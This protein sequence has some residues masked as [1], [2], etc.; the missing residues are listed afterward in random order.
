MESTKSQKL[1]NKIGILILSIV[2]LTANAVSPILNTMMKAFP[3]VSPTTVQS[4]MT[5]PTF[6]IMIFTLLAGLMANIVGKKRLLLIGLGFYT[7]GGMLPLIL[8]D[9]TPLLISRL[10]LGAGIGFVNPVAAS[11]I[12]DFF[13][14]S[15]R[16]QMMG[17]KSVA[18]SLGQVITVFIVGL[19]AVVNW[20]NSFWVYAIGI[21][22]FVICILWVPSTPKIA[23]VEQ[24]TKKTAGSY[25]VN[26]GV[27]LIAIG[28]GLFNIGYIT[29]LSNFSTIIA[30]SGLGGPAVAGSLI[31]TMTIFIMFSSLV[32]GFSYKIFKNLA[33]VIGAVIYVVGMLILSGATTIGAITACCVALGIG[34]G[35]IVPHVYV[36]LGKFSPK[37]STTFCM[38]VMLIGVNLASF[39]CPYIVTWI[40]TIL[41]NNT[42]RF[43]YEIAAVF[44]IG[45]VVLSIINFISEKRKSKSV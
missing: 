13:D 11:L 34:N 40:A 23:Q 37:T 3:D 17:F 20:K 26:L 16:A 43:K 36:L 44:L 27:I 7:I 31:S 15:E 18:A 30:Q 29:F 1:L 25:K 19:L 41:G 6:A 9:F 39:F 12:V 33:S 28:M 10:L 4:F 2:V 32:F 5:M 8:N 38:S 45:V 24:G 14:G 42:S 21:L 35:L 22:V